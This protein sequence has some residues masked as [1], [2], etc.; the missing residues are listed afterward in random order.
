MFATNTPF[1]A[2]QCRPIEARSEEL[3]STWIRKC[4]VKSCDK[5]RATIV[6]QTVQT[7]CDFL[8]YQLI[9]HNPKIT[10]NA[11]PIS[12]SGSLFKPHPTF[13]CL[14]Q[15]SECESTSISTSFNFS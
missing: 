7:V 13:R 14:L 8:F 3:A 1:P 6:D 9:A 2:T 15:I 4:S 11:S 10:N 5:L 12:E